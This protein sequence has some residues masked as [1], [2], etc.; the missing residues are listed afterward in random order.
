MVQGSIF[1]VTKFLPKSL[2]A[3][4]SFEIHIR[5]CKWVKYQCNLFLLYPYHIIKAIFNRSNL[6]L[7]QKSNS[8]RYILN[9]LRSSFKLN[10][11]FTSENIKLE[12]IDSTLKWSE[13]TK[14][15]RVLIS[16]SS[17]FFLQN[18]GLIMKP[19]K[20]NR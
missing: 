6:H 16:Q 13:F 17:D 14:V 7:S 11:T 15:W 10:E 3:S 5:G 20:A 4:K 18:Y 8:F 2:S 1:L 19:K 9:K 12:S